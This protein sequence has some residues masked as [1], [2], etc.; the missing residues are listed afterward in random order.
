[1]KFHKRSFLKFRHYINVY[2][3][4]DALAGP[5][6]GSFYGVHIA[7]RYG[8]GVPVPPGTFAIVPE[9]QQMA[10]LDGDGFTNLRR[11]RGQVLIYNNV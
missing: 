7:R 1:M 4:L 9:V 11:G 5:L 2:G 10:D 6:A 3:A 8:A